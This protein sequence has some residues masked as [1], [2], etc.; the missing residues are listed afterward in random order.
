MQYRFHRFCLDT[1]HFALYDDGKKVDLEP[2]VLRLLQY[3]I[4]N[5]D[6]V[7]SRTELLDKVFGRHIVSDNALTVRIRTARQSVGDTA[8][9]QKVIATIQG[10]GYRFVADVDTRAH[11][12]F[13]RQPSVPSGS[14]LNEV[15]ERGQSIPDHLFTARPSIAVL[16]FEVIGGGESDS[17]QERADQ[18]GPGGHRY[19]FDRLLNLAEHTLDQEG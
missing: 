15:D 3:L 2:Q 19:E 4:E 16:P 5:R 17:D 14:P 6:R 1:A 13:S 9:S 12:S 11:T 7:V 18:P 10:S 8:R